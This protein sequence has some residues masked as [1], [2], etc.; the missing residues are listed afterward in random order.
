LAVNLGSTRVLNYRRPG[1]QKVYFVFSINSFAS[2]AYCVV[3][4]GAFT[5]Q[6]FPG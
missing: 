1:A 3:N 6:F 4:S 5:V 2:D